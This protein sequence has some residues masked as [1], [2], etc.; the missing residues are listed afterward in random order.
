MTIMVLTEGN[1]PTTLLDDGL[2]WFPAW[3]A[4]GESFFS[5]SM[6]GGTPS[7][8]GFDAL[9]LEPRE[10]TSGGAGFQW[11]PAVSQTGAIAYDHFD[12]QVDIHW[13]SVQAPEIDERITFVTGDNFGPR[14]SPDGTKIVWMRGPPYDLWILD[15][16]T[17]QSRQLTTD[18]PERPGAS[19]RV[20]DWSPDGTDV[21]FLS[22]RGGGAV[23]LWI[24]DVATGLARLLTDHE[25]PGSWH[26]G[27]TQAGPRWAPDGRVIGYLA[28]AGDHNTVWLV[29]PDGTN[30]RQSKVRDA[31]SFE[32]YKDSQR[33]IYARRAPDRSGAV[34]VRAA[35]LGTGEDNLLFEGAFS[36]VAVSPDGSAMTVIS[37]VSHFTMEL[38]LQRLRPTHSATELPSTDGPLEQITHGNG[39]WHVHA[40]GFSRDGS[41]IVYAR[42]RDYGDIYLIRPTR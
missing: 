33:L 34:E 19:D 13:L 30:R 36:E 27:D 22:D 28:P 29:N 9:T 39:E 38:L 8:W 2:Q 31:F 32:W 26:M 25:L 35:H 37:S 5:M 24:V 41:S 3:S 18:P 1:E 14:I 16:T 6:L 7:I 20:G 42:D 17:G 21:V 10:Y 40:G 4:D 12:H 15:R 11:T 23:Q